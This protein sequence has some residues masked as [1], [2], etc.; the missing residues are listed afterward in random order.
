MGDF[1]RMLFL[2]CV[3]MHDLHTDLVQAILDLLSRI[4]QES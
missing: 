2:R 3:D 1:C 4:W